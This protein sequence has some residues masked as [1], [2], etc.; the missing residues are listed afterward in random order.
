MKIYIHLYLNKT[1]VPDT[2]ED[3][4]ID[5][6]ENYLVIPASDEEINTEN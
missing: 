5:P 3:N 4:V 1:N 6:Y 2:D